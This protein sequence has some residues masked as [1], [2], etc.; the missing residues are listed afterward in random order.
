MYI[1]YFKQFIMFSESFESHFDY[2]EEKQKHDTWKKWL[3]FFDKTENEKIK[4][5]KNDLKNWESFAHEHQDNATDE[6]PITDGKSAIKAIRESLNW[7]WYESKNSFS[8]KWPNW[9]DINVE[10]KD[11]SIYTSIQINNENLEITLS[12]FE[13]Q[14]WEKNE[15]QENENPINVSYSGNMSE[16]NLQNLF[17]NK[18]IK[19]ISDLTG[20]KWIDFVK[21]I[22]NHEKQ[23][24]HW[25][26]DKS[27][28]KF[29]KKNDENKKW[30]EEQ[31]KK[32]QELWKKNTEKKIL[33]EEQLVQKKI[34]ENLEKIEKELEQAYDPKWNWWIWWEASVEW[35]W[36]IA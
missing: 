14:E 10:Y 27:K 35:N 16:K 4:S 2:E 7:K 25:Y 30:V 6:L 28:S 3:N 18:N 11:W 36:N 9:E 33:K 13:K 8:T 19:N 17:W 21:W 15:K 34:D 32:I 5:D 1:L 22:Q 12:W 31:I 20:Q 26:V 24:V 23:V 29:D